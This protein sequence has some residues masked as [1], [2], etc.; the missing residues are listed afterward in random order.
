MGS[1]PVGRKASEETALTR[2]LL[3]HGLFYGSPNAELPGSDA[4]D[5]VAVR[6]G[7]QHD[8]VKVQAGS[9]VVPG[10][11]DCGG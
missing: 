4:R 5:I 9:A 1:G 3:L 11:A 10:H 2:L 7:F 6:D 8:R